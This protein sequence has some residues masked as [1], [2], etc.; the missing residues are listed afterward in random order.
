MERKAKE[1]HNR[2]FKNFVDAI[3]TISNG[4]IDFDIPFRE[5]G[6]YGVPAKSNVFLMPTV[7]C[8]VSLVEQPFFLIALED[9]EIAHFE[10]V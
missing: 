2:D 9:I 8:L 6:F 10:R 4:G 3:Q 7:N 1:K 5:L